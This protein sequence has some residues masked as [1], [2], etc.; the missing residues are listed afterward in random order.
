MIK[1]YGLELSSD[2]NSKK[3]SAF[4]DS[5]VEEAIFMK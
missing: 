2:D 3:Q 4:E 1:S 5:E